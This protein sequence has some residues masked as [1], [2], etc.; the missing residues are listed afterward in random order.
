MGARLTRAKANI[1][2]ACIPFVVP[3]SQ[4][5]AARLN[6]VLTV[7]LLM[8][9]AGNSYRPPVD[10]D[11]YVEA[12]Y[13]ARMLE[14]PRKGEAAWPSR[15][16]RVW[17]QDSRCLI[18]WR[19]T[20]TLVNTT[21]LPGLTFWRVT[22]P[23]RMRRPRIAAQLPVPPILPTLYSRSSGVIGCASRRLNFRAIAKKKA[24]L[25]LGQVQQGGMR[26]QEQTQ[27]RP[28]KST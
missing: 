17:M 9:S 23:G 14:D 21:T 4:N 10:H 20:C 11:W 13:L 18:G 12:A 3:G 7:V 16:R 15:K 1:P 8:F 5:W 28:R 25:S 24:E 19:K 26:T 6:S 22:V 27:L 2:A